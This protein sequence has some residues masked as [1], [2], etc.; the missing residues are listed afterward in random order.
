[1]V[2]FL[3][4]HENGGSYRSSIWTHAAT[5]AQARMILIH[6]GSVVLPVVIEPVCSFR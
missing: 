4:D 1:M 6:D 2:S 3:G 5:G